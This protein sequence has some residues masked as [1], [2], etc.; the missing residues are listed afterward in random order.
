MVWNVILTGGAVLMTAFAVGVPVSVWLSPHRQEGIDPLVMFLF[1]LMP[2]ALV[3]DQV[4][5]RFKGS[6]PRA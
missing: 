1:L 3:W 2:V 5:K 6:D 4:I